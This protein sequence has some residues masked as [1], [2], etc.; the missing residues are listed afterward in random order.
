MAAINE[1]TY[2]RYRRYGMQFEPEVF[3]PEVFHVDLHNGMNIQMPIKGRR[4]SAPERGGRGY[5]PKI[6]IWA[7]GTE[8]PDEPAR[9]A[10]MEVVASAGLAW[11]TAV[12][13]YLLDGDH[14]VNR[15]TSEFFGGVSIQLDRSRPP[16][17]KEE[18]QQA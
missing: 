17:E 15:N 4:A 3:H 14:Q 12:L 13:Q 5:D 11:D 6:T 8:A 7:G 16:E 9:G 18:D 10:W 1:R 2:G